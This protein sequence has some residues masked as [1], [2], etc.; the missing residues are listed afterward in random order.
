MYMEDGLPM[1]LVR[2]HCVKRAVAQ[3]AR[4]TDTHT[5][6]PFVWVDR[7]MRRVFNRGTIIM[8]L[9]HIFHG[10]IMINS[11][12]YFL[13]DLQYDE[14]PSPNVV[15]HIVITK[16]NPKSVQCYSTVVEA[17]QL[18]LSGYVTISRNVGFG[19]GKL[20]ICQMEC[21]HSPG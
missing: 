21:G 4:Q 10:S 13:Y 11:Y 5:H 9:G 18:S 3:M 20:G 17:E 12:D 2:T 6:T 1:C 8:F 7:I 15:L 16:S 19:M 14:C